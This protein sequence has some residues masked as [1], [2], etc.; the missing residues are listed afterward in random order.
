MI[1]S[2][3][4]GARLRKLRAEQHLTKAEASERIGVTLRTLSAL[5]QDARGKYYSVLPAIAR[6]YGCTIDSLYP[7]MDGAGAEKEDTP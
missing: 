4:F 3:S 2:D 1:Q 5:E 7:E 6:A